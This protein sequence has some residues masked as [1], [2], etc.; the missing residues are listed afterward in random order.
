MPGYESVR[1]RG[2]VTAAATLL[3]LLG[4]LGA[5][6]ASLGVASAGR[7]ADAARRPDAPAP[8]VALYVGFMGLLLA[9]HVAQIVAGTGALRLRPWARAT[10]LVSSAATAL[11]WIAVLVGSL[12]RG[13][14][15]LGVLLG[16]LWVV[17]GA[18]V[19]ALLLARRTFD[20]S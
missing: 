9:L 4:I 10:G 14:R 3:L 8:R 5:G 6:Y 17:G 18:A 20:R 15:Q 11:L 7:V 1:R 2:S 12:A 16:L 13:S 19:V